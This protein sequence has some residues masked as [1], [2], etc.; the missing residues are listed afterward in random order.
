MC[1]VAVALGSQGDVLPADHL[2]EA[3][4]EFE[5]G[6]NGSSVSGVAVAMWARYFVPMAFSSLV[7]AASCHGGLPFLFSPIH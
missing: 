2:G 6:Q 3:R 1:R 5:V 4:D 7:A